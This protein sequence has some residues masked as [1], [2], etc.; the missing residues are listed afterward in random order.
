MKRIIFVWSFFFHHYYFSN[1]YFFNYFLVKVL[2]GRL[3]VARN[4]PSSALFSNLPC[5]QEPGLNLAVRCQGPRADTCCNALCYP[6]GGFV[7]SLP[8]TAPATRWPPD[9]RSTG[10][11]THGSRTQLVENA[12]PGQVSHQLRITSAYSSRGCG[13]GRE[14]HYEWAFELW[15]DADSL[16]LGFFW[17]RHPWIW[18]RKKELR[19][20]WC[21]YWSH[22]SDKN[23]KPDWHW[24]RTN[25]L[26]Q[27][28]WKPEFLQFSLGST[29]PRTLK[30]NSWTWLGE[31]FSMYEILELYNMS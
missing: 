31:V 24:Q 3:A 26:T 7:L 20:L 9:R 27:P 14:K 16:S 17:L 13:G 6:S 11:C 4:N 18:D 30:V 15:S 28:S 25:K 8:K 21:D 2:N 12:Q 10:P 19:F 1:D 22:R 5:T 29:E 23:T